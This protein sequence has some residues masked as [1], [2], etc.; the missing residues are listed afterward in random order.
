MAGHSK[1]ANIKHRKA[2]QDKKRSNIFTKVAREIIVAAKLGNPDPNF[3]PR[4][5][6][7][8]TAAKKI[9]MPKDK[10][11]AALKK[12]SSNADGENYE[13]IR[14]EGYAPGGVAIIIEALSDNRNRTAAEVRTI[15]A[16]SGG[17]LGESGSVSFMFDRIGYI[18]YKSSIATE[19]EMLEIAIEA[20]AEEAESDEEMHHIITRPEDLAEVAKIIAQKFGEPEEEKLS[21][22]ANTTS[23]VSEEQ[24]EKINNIIEKL[25]DSDDVKEVFS[26]VS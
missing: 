20:G 18:C 24:A 16:K 12:A 13:E 17:N 2:A 1:F 21:W 4:L 19:D 11:D 26:N 3:N 5:R 14:Y 23:E 22:R 9:S 6:Q 7:A 10:I 15:L 25:E 8:I